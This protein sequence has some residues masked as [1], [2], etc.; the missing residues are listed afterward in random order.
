MSLAKY[1]K[2]FDIGVQNPNSVGLNLDRIVFDVLVNDSH[3][4]DGISSDRVSIPAGGTG[5]GQARAAHHWR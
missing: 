1:W 2:F 4:V 5:E 3:V